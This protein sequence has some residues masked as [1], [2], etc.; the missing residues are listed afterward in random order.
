MTDS[1]V[2][3]ADDYEELGTLEFDETVQ[4]AERVRFYT[5]EEQLTDAYDK[6]LPRDRRPT[7]FELDV[8]RRDN[9]YIK[10]L[11]S[12][13]VVEG[14]D[15]YTVRPDVRTSVDVPWVKPVY[16]FT[17]NDLFVAYDWKSSYASLFTNLSAPNFYTRLAQALPRPFPVAQGTDFP[18]SSPREFVNDSGRLPLR[19]LPSFTRTSRPRG[20]MRLVDVAME[21]TADRVGLRG[22]FLEERPLDIP[23][24]MTEH[25]FLSSRKAGFVE[26][27]LPL[28]EAFP[29]M[30]AILVHG[31]PRTP[32][33]YREGTPY[34]KLYD[35]RL[36]DIPWSLW[37]D[38]FPPVQVHEGAPVVAPIEWPQKEPSQLGDSI[39]AVYGT[40][41]PGNVA[42]R[43]WLMA[44]PDAGGV[45]A[46]DLL[47]RSFGLGSVAS[48]AVPVPSTDTLDVLDEDACRFNTERFEEFATQGILRLTKQGI[49]C[50]PLELITQERAGVGHSGHLPYEEGKG[51]EL[52]KEYRT[53]LAEHTWQVT[54]GKPPVYEPLPPAKAPS[55]LRAKVLAVYD[56]EGRFTDDKRKDIAVLLEGA[57]LSGKLYLD[58]EDR[59]VLCEHALAILD[60]KLEEDRQTFYETWAVITDG[61]RTC[62]HCGQEINRD[63]LSDQTEYTEE[64]FVI[65]RTAR[66]SDFTGAHHEQ[67][68]ALSEE[69]RRLKSAVTTAGPVEDILYLLASLLQAVPDGEQTADVLRPIRKIASAVAKKKGE[70]RAEQA[71]SLGAGGVVAMILLLQT[72]QPVLLPRRTFGPKPLVLSGYPRDE[73]TP[74]SYSIL[75][76]MVNVIRRTFASAPDVYN[77]EGREFVRLCVREPG[78]AMKEVA[79]QVK[80]VVSDTKSVEGQAI[81]TLLT[82]AKARHLVGSR[83]EVAPASL[84]VRPFSLPK[85]FGTFV[86][87]PPCASASIVIYTPGKPVSVSQKNVALRPGILRSSFAKDV[88]R[89]STDVRVVPVATPGTEL[90]RRKLAAKK[91]FEK[92]IVKTH[93]LTNLALAS[94]LRSTFAV[95][96]D[97]A[98]IPLTSSPAVLRD[99]SVALVTDTFAKTAKHPAPEVSTHL[100]DDLAFFCLTADISSAKA[101]VST[102]RARE[103][104]AYVER[105]AARSDEERE[106]IGTLI[107]LGIA[108]HIISNKDRQTWSGAL[109]AEIEAPLPL[110]EE[111]DEIE[112]EIVREGEDQE[113]EI[114]VG[115]DEGAYGDRHAL[116]EGRDYAQDYMLSEDE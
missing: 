97:D 55:D 62:K 26:S 5:L 31:V 99:E 38:R 63:V 47:K 25:P 32:H 39:S 90:S 72:H 20:E 48:R 106:I 82:E 78:R 35:V 77:G 19:A 14:V 74:G 49:R 107:R 73:D 92:Y 94:Y 7:S 30:D 22:Y 23:N 50:I 58:A 104:V 96:S 1:L 24:P 29:D 64:G 4:R 88:S 46:N 87:F 41:Y 65:Q 54:A 101:N 56:D 85:E 57:H 83:E 37:K 40:A 67:T 12:R 116:P 59:F 6:Q 91:E 11:Y 105:M 18:I 114:P 75:N 80:F 102:L 16:E 84:V 51:E 28:T 93:P 100:R 110:E 34:L 81:R 27:T 42:E 89:I 69:L 10:E 61:A 52:L 53:R 44:R 8:L 113:V 109:E 76:E 71:I 79:V 45:I 68:H 15:T 86:R 43:Y 9:A 2:W 36:A 112:R 111:R 3:E 17:G 21:G 95:G 108:P 103:R 115:G 66:L 98:L 60:G 33:P 13:Y 70:N